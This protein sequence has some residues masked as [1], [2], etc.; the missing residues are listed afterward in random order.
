MKY[1]ECNEVEYEVVLTPN[2]KADKINQLEQY[3]IVCE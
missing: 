1:F 2:I 3:E